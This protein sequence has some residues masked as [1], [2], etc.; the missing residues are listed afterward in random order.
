MLLYKSWRNPCMYKSCNDGLSYDM[1]Y[2]STLYFSFITHPLYDVFYYV[3]S[4]GC[5]TDHE[6]PIGSEIGSD[7][8]RIPKYIMLFK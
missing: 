1:V 5:V 7:L 3:L 4:M 6:Y 8:E 2:L